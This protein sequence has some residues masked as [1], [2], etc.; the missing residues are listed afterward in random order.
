MKEIRKGIEY[1]K[2]ANIKFEWEFLEG[3]RW[4]G[5]GT[6]PDEDAKYIIMQYIG[7]YLNGKKWNGKTYMEGSIIIKEYKDGIEYVKEYDS[8]YEGRRGSCS[9]VSTSE[10]NIR[11]RIFRRWK[12]WMRKGI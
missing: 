11:R 1:F 9:R 3:I 2:D 7:E 6:E 8:D 4:N 10:C 5:K 12:T